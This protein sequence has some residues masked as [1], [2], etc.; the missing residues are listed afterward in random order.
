MKLLFITDKGKLVKKLSQILRENGYLVDH[1]ADG[2]TGL[3]MSAGGSYNLIIL[4]WLMSKGDGISIMKEIRS[5]G[6]DTP[7]LMIGDK[8]TP[9]DRAD[10]LDSGADD[11]L[12]QPF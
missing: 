1:A 10:G 12:S 6:L 2:Q 4:E 5:Q 7:V 9:R 11:F 3:E 8:D